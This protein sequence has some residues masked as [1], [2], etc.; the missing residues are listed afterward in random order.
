MW[1][2]QKSKKKKEEEKYFTSMEREIFQY[3]TSFLNVS[4]NR[5][6]KGRK[7]RKKIRGEGKKRCK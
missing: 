5:R 7:I 4:K 2:E 1:R 3:Q 6:G